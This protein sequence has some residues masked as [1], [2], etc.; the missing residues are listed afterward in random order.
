MLRNT[1]LSRQR[2]SITQYCLVATFIVAGM[3]FYSGVH[4]IL[5]LDRYIEYVSSHR[6]QSYEMFS[7]RYSDD[8]YLEYIGEFV[9]K[10]KLPLTAPSASSDLNPTTNALVEQLYDLRA[11]LIYFGC[12]ML[13]VLSGGMVWLT[14]S[15]R[16]PF[17]TIANAVDRLTQNQLDQTIDL[18]GPRN[19][20][21]V[22]NKLESLRGRLH[23]NEQQR[24]LF[25]RHV[26]HE[27]K[28]PL[29]S[30]KE[31]ITLLDDESLGGLTG[32]QRDVIDILRRASDELQNLT[33]GKHHHQ[34][35]TDN[36]TQ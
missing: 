16:R 27:I 14:D 22:S 6:P 35:P 32:D 24:T 8:G 26:S 5:L 25:L 28:T 17:N 36:T 30:I 15:V 1:L 12:F 20:L 11:G 33:I 4:S 29:A 7:P 9:R 10:A 31:G 19:V 34:A 3:G 23:N 13:A 2:L 21:E 18:V